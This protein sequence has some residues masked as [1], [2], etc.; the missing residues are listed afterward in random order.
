MIQRDIKFEI[1][2]RIYSV[3]DYRIMKEKT[4]G[5]IIKVGIKSFES[6]TVL[7]DG[8]QGVVQNMSA[9]ELYLDEEYAF[10]QDL[11]KL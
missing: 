6:Y 10:Y 3:F 7:W 11:L 1:G 2:D 4:M 8:P 5:T 9:N